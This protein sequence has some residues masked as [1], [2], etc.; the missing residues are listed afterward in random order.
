VAFSP[1]WLAFGFCKSK[2][3]LKSPTKRHFLLSYVVQHIL[4]IFKK[5]NQLFILCNITNQIMAVFVSFFVIF[6]SE[7]LSIGAAANA[8]LW[9]S[10]VHYIH[11]RELIR[12]KHITYTLWT[13]NPI[14]VIFLL[15]SLH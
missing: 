5:N 15:P 1:F 6:N 8:M 7:F 10:L 11:I 9:F 3:R 14:F 2:S 4:E 13:S 12:P